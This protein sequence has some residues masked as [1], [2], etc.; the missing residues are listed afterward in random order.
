M[1][2]ERPH[3]YWFILIH[4]SPPLACSAGHHGKSYISCRLQT[5]LAQAQQ[6][7]GFCVKHAVCG[8]KQL[9]K[10]GFGRKTLVL[11]QP[12]F[13]FKPKHVCKPGFWKRPYWERLWK[14]PYLERLCGYACKRCSAQKPVDQVLDIRSD[15]ANR[16]QTQQK[17]ETTIEMTAR[18]AK[19]SRCWARRGQSWA[20]HNVRKDEDETKKS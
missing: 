9:F 8:Y 1:V 14:M 4:I 3:H 6:E 5:A 17:T 15:G 20:H 19:P 10:R 13:K 16:W 11:F 12:R 2:E 7:H 18:C